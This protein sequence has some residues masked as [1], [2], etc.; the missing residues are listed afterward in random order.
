MVKFEMVYDVF[1]IFMSANG[2]IPT[3]ATASPI[4][5]AVD[6]PAIALSDFPLASGLDSIGDLGGVR[7]RNGVY[8][9]AEP[10][11]ATTST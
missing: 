1:I 2:I 6:D 9:R 7:C 8:H 5:V 10:F 11:R 4:D 3:I